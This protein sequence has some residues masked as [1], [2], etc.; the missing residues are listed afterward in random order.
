MYYSYFTWCCWAS[1]TISPGMQWSGQ[2]STIFSAS[3]TTLWWL[4]GKACKEFTRAIDYSG[5]WKSGMKTLWFCTGLPSCLFSCLSS[6]HGGVGQS[7][8]YILSG[9]LKYVE[10]SVQLWWKVFNI[11]M[12]R[13]WQYFCL[14]LFPTKWIQMIESWHIS[15]QHLIRILR[16][17]KCNWYIK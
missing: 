11:G 4:N 13:F 16:V 7:I 8:Q 3:T 9:F 10:A 15:D 14:I 2:E 5:P 12:S 6:E 17:S 1:C